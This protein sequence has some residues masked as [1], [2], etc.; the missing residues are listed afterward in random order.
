MLVSVLERGRKEDI[1][2]NSRHGPSQLSLG[3]LLLESLGISVD[4][5]RLFKGR[6]TATHV[7]CATDKFVVRGKDGPVES[8]LERYKAVDGADCGFL[9][10]GRWDLGRSPVALTVYAVCFVGNIVVI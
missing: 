2:I 4:A 7:G 9:E 3:F 1:R 5:P 8:K 6:D 10:E